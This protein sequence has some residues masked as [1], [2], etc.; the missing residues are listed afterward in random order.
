MLTYDQF[1]ALLS[2]V[3]PRRFGMLREQ[4]EGADRDEDQEEW[5]VLDDEEDDAAIT[6]F[7]QVM[8]LRDARAD[9]AEFARLNSIT[10]V[11]QAAV[12][13]RADR[14]N[15]TAEEKAERERR[16]VVA[17]LMSDLSG[18]ATRSMMN[19][20]VEVMSQ[21]GYYVRRAAAARAE[22]RIDAAAAKLAAALNEGG[23]GGEGKDG[24]GDAGDAGDEGDGEGDGEGE[25]EGEGELLVVRSLCTRLTH[26]IGGFGAVLVSRQSVAEMVI[27]EEE[28]EGGLVL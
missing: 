28:E 19:A 12:T 8:E 17:D 2:D 24:D 3:D 20:F 1:R 14:A 4:K 23:D 15:E 18:D 25:G 7:N 10:R 26:R 27:E 5:D 21:E 11:Q 16:E 13:P 6:V 9:D 22:K